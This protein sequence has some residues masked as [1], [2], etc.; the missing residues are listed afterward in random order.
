MC[1]VQ[2]ASQS[3]NAPAAT[4][5]LNLYWEICIPRWSIAIEN[6]RHV[7]LIVFSDPL[8][9]LLLHVCTLSPDQIETCVMG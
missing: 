6:N 3:L 9:F 4:L 1:H 5:F 8:V 2:H 7:D